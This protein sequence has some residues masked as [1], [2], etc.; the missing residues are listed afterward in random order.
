[1]T[2]IA[3]IRSLLHAAILLAI[4]LTALAA[5]AQTIAVMPVNIFLPPGEM[6]T[7]ISITNKGTAETAIQ[8]RAFDWAIKDGEDE[9]A[10]ATALLVSPP[11][12]T[13]APG[14]SQIIR[15]VLRQTPAAQEA[16]Y[17]ILVDQIPPAS[18]A[19]TVRIV[20]RLSLPVFAEPAAKARPAIAFHLERSPNPK[21][22][23]K[24]DELVLVG[25]NTGAIHDVLRKIELTTRDG[26]KLHTAKGASPYILANST[27]RWPI[28]LTGMTGPLPQPGDSIL[29]TAQGINTPIHEQVSLAMAH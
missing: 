11:L 24:Q 25:V 5:S 29:L 21:L 19:G 28:D 20:V 8:I 12:A 4:V 26:M 22:D 13:I 3:Q 16:T 10:P 9:L 2:R 7:T 14:A 23:P 17:R 1:M 27:Q 15:L 18:S 6:A